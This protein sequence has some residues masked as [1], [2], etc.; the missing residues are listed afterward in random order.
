MHIPWLVPFAERWRAQQQQERAPH[1]LL[2][3]GVPG[4]GKRCA[5]AWLALQRL[6]PAVA[7]VSPQYPFAVPSHPDLHWLSKPEDKQTI[8]IDQIRALIAELSLTSH[9]GRGKVAVIEPANILTHQAA[10]SLLKTLEEPAGNALI[11]LIADRMG[12][13]PATILSRCQRIAFPVPDE[14]TSL[15]WL[16]E[17]QPGQ[18]WP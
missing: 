2:L 9:A 18:H 15:A 10:N 11:I 3:L 7:P 8:L 13:L 17:L 12:R 5:A 16:G 1:A 4:V 14:A 6:A